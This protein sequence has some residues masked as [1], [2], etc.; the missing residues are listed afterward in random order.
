MEKEPQN[1]QAEIQTKNNK[2]IVSKWEEYGLI[3]L[4]TIDWPTTISGN[5][6]FFR[7][8][9]L[10]ILKKISQK[11]YHE[12]EEFQ[13]IRNISDS[14]C[15]PKVTHN[16]IMSRERT[17]K[18]LQ[19]L[20]DSNKHLFPNHLPY[21]PLVNIDV[22]S[23]IFDSN[24]NVCFF[25]IAFSQNDYTIGIYLH[26]FLCQ[27]EKVLW[28]IENKFSTI[29][30]MKKIVTG[31]CLFGNALYG[32]DQ[33]NEKHLLSDLCARQNKTTKIQKFYYPTIEHPYITMNYKM[34]EN[35]VPLIKILGDKDTE[36]EFH[37]PIEEYCL[38][39]IKYFLEGYF[40]LELLNKYFSLIN[41]RAQ[42][43]R[44]RLNQLAQKYQ[45]KF[46]F[47]SPL[48]C[49]IN[50][51]E[52]R[53]FLTFIGLKKEIN[54]ILQ[55][56]AE[57]I[58]YKEST[59]NSFVAI[60]LLNFLAE[61]EGAVG[62]IWQHARIKLLAE[63]KLI[64]LDTIQSLSYTIKVAIANREATGI[65]TCLIDVIY[66]KP[67]ADNYQ[68]Y[69]ADHYGAMLAL[70]WLP[71]I[72]FQCKPKH[73]NNFIYS[74]TE[75]YIEEI[76]QYIQEGLIEEALKLTGAAIFPPLPLT[77]SN[78]FK[79]D[80]SQ[81][82]ILTTNSYLTISQMLSTKKKV[83]EECIDESFPLQKILPTSRQEDHENR[84]AEFSIST[85]HSIKK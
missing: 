21:H 80:L 34:L 31:I 29:P 65:S 84:L 33:E 42:D 2:L 44:R 9:R 78:E 11:K 19:R 55:A 17:A 16:H 14:H 32:V 12:K 85:I 3:A 67:I 40:S 63:K 61:Q 10:G 59:L 54:E 57:S 73:A 64:G 22:H 76:N 36:I 51:F 30:I 39:G 48:E 20:F 46:K 82:Q 71:P 79:T 66:E 24:D 60:K 49:L 72:H 45:L 1:K 52:M 69:F 58:L 13:L 6:F 47:T 50:H 62:N 41:D 75:E 18:L 8:N 26:A 56:Q 70:Y 27:N 15:K 7:K 28:P 43:H 5:T 38:G 81:T 23:I 53:N 77:S 74:V 83:V 37:L 4:R 35:L 25:P 68:K